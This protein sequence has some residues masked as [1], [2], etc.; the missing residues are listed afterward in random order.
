VAFGGTHN[1]L[2]E[3]MIY[4][5]K[6]M[7]LLSVLFA[8]DEP[9]EVMGYTREQWQWCVKYERA[10]WNRLIERKDL[11]RSEQRVISSYLNDG[12][13][14]SEISQD[15]PGRLGTWVGWRIVESYMEHHEQIS[16]QQLMQENDAQ[17]ILE[18]SYYK[19]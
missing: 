1:R 2:L 5:G 19:P 11:F 12:P 14:T 18:D 8:E 13:F 4:R 7:Y 10:I 9:W 15:S 6:V 3:Q 16:M 17:H